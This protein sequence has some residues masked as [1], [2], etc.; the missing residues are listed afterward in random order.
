MRCC[1]IH[2]RP[3]SVSVVTVLTAKLHRIQNN[4]T[5]LICRSTGIGFTAHCGRWDSKKDTNFRLPKIGDGFPKPEPIP[6]SRACFCFGWNGV[7]LF[8][9]VFSVVASNWD[10]HTRARSTS[11]C[12]RM[13]KKATK[14]DEN[15]VHT[16]EHICFLVSFS[17]MSCPNGFQAF[18]CNLLRWI[19]FPDSMGFMISFPNP[20]DFITKQI[21]FAFHAFWFFACVVL[22]FQAAAS[23]TISPRTTANFGHY[24]VH[25]FSGTL[26]FASL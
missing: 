8:E 11:E 5:S 19:S 26:E 12:N 14:L 10:K 20:V 18:G 3:T 21:G 2:S 9:Y 17:K 22:S 1:I 13:W 16:L 7:S 23:V 24:N 4:S 25:C 15:Y 6:K